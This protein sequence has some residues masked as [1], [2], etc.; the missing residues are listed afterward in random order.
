MWEDYLWH[1]KKESPVPPRQCTVPQV[2]ENDGQI[3]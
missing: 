1:T 3:E 2:R